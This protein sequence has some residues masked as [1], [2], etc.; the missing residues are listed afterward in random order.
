MCSSNFAFE[1]LDLQKNENKE[2][3]S[4]PNVTF[5]SS[6]NFERKRLSLK[7]PSAVSYVMKGEKS[8]GAIFIRK[9]QD[10]K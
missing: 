8:L 6:D 5:M 3:E 1:E 2:S 4:Y 7:A 9:K 10:Y